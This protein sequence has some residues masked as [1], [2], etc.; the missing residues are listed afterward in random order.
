MTLS[1]SITSSVLAWLQVAADAREVKLL[2]LESAIN[3]SHSG[4]NHGRSGLLAALLHL[5]LGLTAA[6]ICHTLKFISRVS[7]TQKA[8]EY[9]LPV[10]Q[11]FLEHF[12]C[13]VHLGAVYEMQQAADY[14]NRRQTDAFAI[15]AAHARQEFMASRTPSCSDKEEWA[16]YDSRQR[17]VEFA[18]SAAEAREVGSADM[19]V[20]APGYC[21]G[22]GLFEPV[23]QPDFGFRAS[24]QDKDNKDDNDDDGEDDDNV[25]NTDETSVE[26]KAINLVSYHAQCSRAEAVAALEANSNDIAFAIMQ[27]METRVHAH[28]TDGV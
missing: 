11:A 26:A 21:V 10:C 28:L 7:W 16:D 2:N 4:S 8:S 5:L 12:S 15:G 13:S 22:S 27:L 24:P 23:G 9:L 17:T 14:D 18:T 6:T 20:D 3:N 25:G 1:M 19:L